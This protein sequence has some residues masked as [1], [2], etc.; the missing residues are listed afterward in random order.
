MWLCVCVCV[1]MCV[2]ICVCVCV[3]VVEMYKMALFFLCV[4]SIEGHYFSSAWSKI[5]CMAR[6]TSMHLTKYY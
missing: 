5:M 3:F 4:C 2:C 6:Q 1:G